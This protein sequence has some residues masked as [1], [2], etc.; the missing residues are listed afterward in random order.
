MPDEPRAGLPSNP[1]SEPDPHDHAGHSDSNPTDKPLSPSNPEMQRRFRTAL[2]IYSVLA[3]LSGV[4]LEG[5]IRNA[6]WLFLGGLAL[7]S[8]IAV[9]R[10]R[11]D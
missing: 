3:V 5:V 7:K 10:D 4:T 6:T 1:T 9:L 11:V 2:A 8:W